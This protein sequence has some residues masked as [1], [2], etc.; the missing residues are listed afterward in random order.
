MHVI[1]THI[2]VC[3][4]IYRR[5]CCRRRRRR[6]SLG[7]LTTSDDYLQV[8]SFEFN[9]LHSSHPILVAGCYAARGRTR[10]WAAGPANILSHSV[11]FAKHRV[12]T[13]R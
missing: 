8:I 12:Q 10:C 4:Y 13:D 2:H 5:R 1:H 9:C 3:V 11:I 6:H 7:P